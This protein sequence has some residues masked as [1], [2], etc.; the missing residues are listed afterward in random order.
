MKIIRFMPYRGNQYNV[1]QI[2][3]T[4]SEADIT[5]NYGFCN[6]KFGECFIAFYQDNIFFLG[7]FDGKNKDAFIHLQQ[8]WP[9]SKLEENKVLASGFVD[10]IFVQDYDNNP[11]F[12]LLVKGTDFQIMV[13]QELLKIKK[14]ELI[15]YKKIAHNIDKKL[16]ARGVGSAVGKN[17]ISYLIPCHRVIG[18]NGSLTGY[19]WGLD[20][21]KIMIEDEKKQTIKM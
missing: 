1:G 15:S 13:W 9:K 6:T 3:E 11:K 16:A 17:P 12:N 21:K 7:F 10:Q 20:V 8:D 5:I 18:N 4:L 2:A 14:G 19:R